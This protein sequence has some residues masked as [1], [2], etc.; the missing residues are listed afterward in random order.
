MSDDAS[1]APVSGSEANSVKALVDLLKS[2]GHEYLDLFTA[3]NEEEF[4]A[5]LLPLIERAVSDLESKKTLFETL[6][7]VA[8]SGV[9]GMGISVP[10]L[11]LV[12]QETHSNGHVDLTICAE[13]CVPVRKRLVEAK[14]YDGAE[15]H[16]KGLKQL[17]ARYMTGREGG[18]ILF[19]YFRSPNIAGLMK[20]IRKRMDDELPLGQQGETTKH[21]LKWSFCSVHAHSCG[22]NI[23]VSHIGCNLYIE[24][25][26]SG[27][28]K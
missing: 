18:G 24:P 19:V 5:A 21:T 2:K 26:A 16:L 6:G 27:L 7:E 14:I 25:S 15:Y 8:L 28:K 17:F 1:T 9:L 10:G 4:D 22:E 11:V 23:G 20:K 13:R 3:T 12:T